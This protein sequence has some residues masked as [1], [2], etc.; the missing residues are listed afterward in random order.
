MSDS[1]VAVLFSCNQLFPVVW[2][3][4]NSEFK[5]TQFIKDSNIIEIYDSEVIGYADSISSCESDSTD[6]NDENGFNCELLI[7]AK[8]KIFRIDSTSHEYFIS[9]TDECDCYRDLLYNEHFDKR[10]HR[11]CQPLIIVVEKG[12]YK[13]CEIIGNL[14]VY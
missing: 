7:D 11:I 3:V 2:D 9:E 5:L 4:F 10:R 13:I 14:K 12:D 1:W 8:H 6:S